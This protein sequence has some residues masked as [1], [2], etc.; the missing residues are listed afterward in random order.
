[1]SYEITDQDLEASN[2][3]EP[4]LYA[5]WGEPGYQVAGIVKEFNARE[6]AQDFNKNVCGYCI[7][8]ADDETDYFVSLDKPAL[9]DA[10]INSAKANNYNS[11]SIIGASIT[12]Q[13][14]EYRT[15]NTTGRKYKFFA[16]KV[17]DGGGKYPPAK[18]IVQP[19][20]KQ[21]DANYDATALRDGEDPF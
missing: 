3:G 4:K 7:V 20:P 13:F 14:K 16:A 9:R 8:A 6:G 19:K 12:I 11:K 18:Y 1:M 10:I 2:S 21:A 17:F 15:S 5:N